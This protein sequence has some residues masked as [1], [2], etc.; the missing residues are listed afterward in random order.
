MKN[1]KTWYTSNN[2]TWL[3]HIHLLNTFACLEFIIEALHNIFRL[4]LKIIWFQQF[5]INW[6]QKVCWIRFRGEEVATIIGFS[7]DIRS[8]SLKSHFGNCQTF[9]NIPV[10]F[11]TNS[12]THRLLSCCRLCRYASDRIVIYFLRWVSSPQ[13]PSRHKFDHDARIVH[14]GG[15]VELKKLL[16]R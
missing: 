13:G 12:P 3:A 8:L 5:M 1:L 7:V 11:T 16:P 4:T 2:I 6:R 9:L 14:S 15:L 10:A